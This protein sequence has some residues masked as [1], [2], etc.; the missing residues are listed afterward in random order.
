MIVMLIVLHDSRIF[1]NL[2]STQFYQLTKSTIM[3]RGT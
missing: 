3:E 2:E 1:H